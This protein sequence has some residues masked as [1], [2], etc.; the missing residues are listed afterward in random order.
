MERSSALEQRHTSPGYD[1]HSHEF[2]GLYRN[3]DEGILR[4]YSHQRG[5]FL[6]S[7]V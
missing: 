5:R 7:P 6:A 3:T 1:A 4:G 2:P